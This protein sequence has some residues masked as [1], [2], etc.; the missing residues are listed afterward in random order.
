MTADVESN[1]SLFAEK[2]RHWNDTVFGH[3]GRKKRELLAW[4]RGVDRALRKNHS[5]FLVQLDVDLR[6]ELD[7]VLRHEESLWLQ[8]LWVNWASFGDR[9]TTYFHR[10]TMQRR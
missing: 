9:N 4:I 7:E 10:Y 1:V 6:A 2:A 8:K 3:I 5:N